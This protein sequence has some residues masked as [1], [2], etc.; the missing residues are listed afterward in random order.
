MVR[1]K[2]GVERGREIERWSEREIE[3]DVYLTPN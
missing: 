1:E 2:E 3:Q